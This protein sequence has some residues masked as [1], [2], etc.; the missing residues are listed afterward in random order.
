[1]TK[2]LVTCGAHPGVYFLEKWFP[3]VEFI[4]GDA[5]FITQISASQQSLLPQVSEGDFIHQ[6][7][8]VCLDNQINAVFA[9]SFAEQE[10][11][12][13]AVELFSEFEI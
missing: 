10:L 1:M 7:L 4:Y 2:V 13:E 11:L 9:M 3:Q 6:L 12:A 5:V 8:N